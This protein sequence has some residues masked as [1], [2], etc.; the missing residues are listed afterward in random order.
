MYKD[1]SSRP[2]I[3]Q[4]ISIGS[5]LKPKLKCGVWIERRGP[6]LY[7]SIFRVQPIY[8]NFTQKDGY[9]HR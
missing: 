9:F 5:I 2:S 6:L 1:A 4:T 7:T 8:G 3:K